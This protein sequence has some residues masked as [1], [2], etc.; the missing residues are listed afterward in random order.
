MLEAEL[1][2]RIEQ[3]VR[4]A[5]TERILREAG[6]E[7]QV[8]AAIAA[9]EKPDGA[10]LAEGIKDLFKQEPDCEWRDHIETEAKKR[11]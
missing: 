7:D 11:T 2:E 1:A 10:A 8:A 3:K 4:A 9:I 5:I 6:F